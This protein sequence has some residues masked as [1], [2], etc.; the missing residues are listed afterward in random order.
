[1]RAI[2]HAESDILP[3]LTAGK[4]AASVLHLE[5]VVHR[6]AHLL[7]AQGPIR[8]FIHH[9]PLHA[10]EHLPFE[11]AV[12][13]GARVFNCHPYLPELRYREKL[14]RGRIRVADLQAVLREDL[15]SRND[16]PIL[17]M[18][19]RIELRLAMLLYPLRLAPTGELRWF[20]ARHDALKSFRDAAPPLLR[21]AFIEETRQWIKRR[22]RGGSASPG[23][24]SPSKQRRV[25]QHG[26]DRQFQ[27]WL[28]RSI[29]RFGESSMESWDEKEWEQL[30]LQVLWRICRDGV[31]GLKIPKPPSS[32]SVR[33]RDLLLAA[34]GQDSDL[35][36]HDVLVR[37]CAAFLD[38]G[39]AHWLLPHRDQGLFRAFSTLYRQ[40]CGP[41]DRWLRELSRELVRL[42][43][44]GLSPA[45][46]VVESLNLLGVLEP[47]WDLFI[48]A[49]LLALRGWAGMM[50]QMETRGDRSAHPAPQGSL[51]EFLAVR[52]ILE[53][54]ALARVASEGL[55][56]QGPLR[57]LREFAAVRI[58]EQEAFNVDQRAFLV[59]HLAQV[60]GW[61]PSDL[62]RLTR[63]EWSTLVEEIGAFS[64]LERR[65]IFQL[66]LE[67]RY[68]IQ[69]LDAL[70]IHSERCVPP[71]SRHPENI[72]SKRGQPQE[73]PKAQIICCL[74]EREESFRRHLEE[75]CP[76]VQTFSAAGFFNVAMYY[77]GVADAHFVPL[78]PVAIRPRHWVVE[79]VMRA[80]SGLHR[81]RAR[82]RRAFGRVLHTLHVISRTFLGGAVL[83]VLGAL[84][85]IP[86]VVR[87]LFPRSTSY[88]WRW[89]GR[90]VQSPALTR[91]DLERAQLRGRHGP[92]E[93]GPAD[94][95]GFSVEEMAEI[96]ERLLRDI[97]LTSS[98]APLV[99]VVG[100]G[101]V[102]LNN[103]HESA[104]D[105]GACGGSVGGPNARALAQMANDPRV[106]ELLCQRGLDLPRETTFLGML[107][108]TCDDSLAFYDL[109]DLPQHQE[110]EFARSRAMMEEAC[111]RNA[112]ER[113]RR[114]EAA[115][116]DLSL[117]AA[118]RHVEGR[119]QDLAETR[120]EY[121]HA[122]NAVCVVGRRQRTRG[123]FM[124]RRAFL[125]S[126]D[127][128]QDDPDHT[129]LTRLLQAA[130]PVCAGINL[131]YYFSYND[132]AGWGCGTKLPHNITSLLGVMDG[133]ASDLRPGLPWQMVEIH[134]PVRLL[135]VVET[136][137]R[138]LERIMARQPSIGKIFRNNWVQLAVLDPDSSA[139]WV[140]RS[141][142]FQLYRPE[143]ERLPQVVSSRD[144]YRGRSDHLGFAE[145][146]TGS[147][148]PS[149]LAVE[150]GEPGA[151]A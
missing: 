85:S 21:E 143:T 46:S 109:Q 9:N 118:R 33:H 123:L 130:T 54:L 68:R 128:T 121:G 104:H 26:R 82:L 142:R 149:E 2:S 23:A 106:R 108:N 102:S 58:P 30:S 28:T 34:T 87:V 125:V 18:G 49:T 32:L 55:G 148:Q 103:P 5:H 111:N 8:V 10:F 84:A 41:P 42:E 63:R 81:R 69:V 38:Q 127:P 57:N 107:H 120:P 90:F 70:A 52:L 29:K 101:S 132:P 64:D 145:I 73:T 74:D 122:T 76:A 65:R 19:T 40:R 17:H 98:F 50:H 4:A 93:H 135:F 117:L 25:Q 115:H 134:E 110:L 78:C 80:M 27:R 37:F 140:Y 14:A 114:F 89:A 88:V 12:Q 119:S 136:A 47:E 13:Q 96:V 72:P 129:V 77:Q 79:K 99:L 66:A 62:H 113:C 22:F 15:G 116:P 137:P 150:T 151:R 31:Q 75:A 36:V 67:R 71:P 61:L 91:L 133:A 105:C 83:A 86:L 100:H 6:A 24:N 126:Y 11:E 56:Y 43:R 53:R 45:E 59:F 20:V 39:L 141:G 16:E 97:G 92:M 112:H 131:E 3:G 94:Q 60:R 138:A 7:P 139:I 144:W 48:P 35:L 95:V 1:M 147:N 44:A 146:E 124:D 51:V